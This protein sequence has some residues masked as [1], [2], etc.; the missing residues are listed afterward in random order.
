MIVSIL[1]TVF[2]TVVTQCVLVDSSTVICWKHPLVILRVLGLF[3]HFYYIPISGKP[4]EMHGL[5]I[6]YRMLY[7]TDVF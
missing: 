2:D 5:S 4:F 1:Q 7:Q 3:H 6:C